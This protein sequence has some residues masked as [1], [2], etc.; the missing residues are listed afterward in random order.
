MRTVPVHRS[1]HRRI[2][3]LGGER[4]LVQ[5]SAMAAFIVSIG[6]QT[7]IGIA[8]AVI[9]WCGAVYALRRMAKTDPHMSQIFDRH[10]RQQDFYPARG[11][12]WRP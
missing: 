9:F 1:L 2:L 6:S 5:L 10:V 3:L 11:S 4:D 8:S 7:V 12:V